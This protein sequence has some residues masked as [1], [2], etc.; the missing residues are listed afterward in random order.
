M[1]EEKQVCRLLLGLLRPRPNGK[2]AEQ[3]GKTRAAD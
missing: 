1:L 3:K 2:L